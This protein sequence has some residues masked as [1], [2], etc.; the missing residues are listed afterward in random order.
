MLLLIA[1]GKPLTRI[2][3]DLSLSVKTIATY[4]ARILE[5]MNMRTNAEI[6]RYVIQRGL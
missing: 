5:K 3:E 2:A 4:R 1:A 6:I